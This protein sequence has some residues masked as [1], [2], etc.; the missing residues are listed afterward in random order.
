VYS[1][2]GEKW[3]LGPQN[4]PSNSPVFTGTVDVQQ[5][6]KRSGDI[7]PPSLSASVNDYAP[8]GFSTASVLRLSSGGTY[9]V[10]GLTAAGDGRLVA[11][12]NYG[13]NTIL[14]TNEDAASAAANRFSL[15][16][17]VVLGAGQGISLIYDAIS[18]RWR[19]ISGASTGVPAS[20]VVGETIMWNQTTPPPNFLVEDG[21]AYSSATYASLYVALVKT[22]NVTVT[23]ASP[24]VVSWPGHNLKTYDPFFFQS[25]LGDTLPAGVTA[26]TVYYVGN[27]VPGVSFQLVS[28]G[29]YVNTS[30]TQSGTHNG[31]NAPF[32]VAANLSTFNVPNTLGEFLRMWDGGR[33]IDAGTIAGLNTRSFG[34]DE[35]D[36]MQGH[37]HTMGATVW[38]TDFVANNSSGTTGWGLVG[39]NSATITGLP[40]GDS[41]NGT[42]RTGQETRPRNNTKLPCIRYQ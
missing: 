17:N 12:Y 41:T 27:V 8:A 40:T 7:S 34:S 38:Q 6:L 20:G 35:L 31:V 29:S 21:A 3:T 37:K 13:A 23:I 19:A 30:G 26:G 11:I 32:G 14:L 24:A 4:N 36:A 1:W 25:G 9:N 10:T 5:A 18:S 2:D 39:T 33:G 16:A 15:G 28:G 42:P 22:S